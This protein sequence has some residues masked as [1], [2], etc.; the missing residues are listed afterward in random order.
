MA[1]QIEKKNYDF[2]IIFL[3]FLR[4]YLV[5]IKFEEKKIERKNKIK[6]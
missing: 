6:K 5:F 1:N 4:L 2:F 3:S